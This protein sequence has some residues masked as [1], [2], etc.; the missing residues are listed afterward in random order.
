MSS[1]NVSPLQEIAQLN[2]TKCCIEESLRLYPPAW[3]T[4]RVNIEDDNIE[5]YSLKKGTILGVSI[6]ELHRNKKY[7]TDPDLFKPERFSEENRKKITPYYMPFGAGPRLCIGNNFAMYEM[8][9][10]VN[11]IIKKFNISTDNSNIRINPL[12]TLKPVGV[13]VNFDLKVS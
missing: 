3:I 1:Q 7:W 13:K 12:I 8:I 10:A 2:Y 4:D 11:T 5:G 6:Y 9:L